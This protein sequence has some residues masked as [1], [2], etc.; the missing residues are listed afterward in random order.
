MLLLTFRGF[1]LAAHNPC[2]LHDF[3]SI[4]LILSDIKTNESFCILFALSAWGP[5]THPGCKILQASLQFCAILIPTISC[6]F[7]FDKVHVISYHFMLL[8]SGS[9]D[10][11]LFLASSSIY[12]CFP[13]SKMDC[14]NRIKIY[15]KSTQ[16][17]TP[18]RSKIGPKS[19]PNHPKMTPW[20][21]HWFFMILGSIWDNFL[22]PFWHHFRSKKDIKNMS[23]IRCKIITKKVHLWTLRW[24]ILG[25]TFDQNV[26]Y[27][28]NAFRAS[29]LSVRVASFVQSSNRWTLKKHC[30]SA[31]K[32]V[33]QQGLHI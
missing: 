19:T 27:F 26:M 31:V 7:L 1:S 25:S 30:I 12:C 32:H 29:I 5:R 22:D 24:P 3:T 23:K 6:D 17:S 13:W 33:F 14:K 9:Y 11:L 20:R 15:P 2:R 28:P 21:E 16:K 8:P 18:N 10:F 4:P